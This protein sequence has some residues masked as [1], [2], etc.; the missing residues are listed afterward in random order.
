MSDIERRVADMRSR[1]E[2]EESIARVVDE[3]IT[4]ENKR[5]WMLNHPFAFL[6]WEVSR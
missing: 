3:F 4:K 2:S 1:G 6:A 5:Y